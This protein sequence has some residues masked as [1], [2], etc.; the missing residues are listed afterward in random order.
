MD[1]RGEHIRGYWGPPGEKPI[2][3]FEKRDQQSQLNRIEQVVDRLQRNVIE[4]ENMCQQQAD[5]RCTPHQRQNPDSGAETNCQGKFLR[6][7]P[8]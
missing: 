6:S 7:Q 8:G 2:P 5:Q 4:S 1:Q 3:Q